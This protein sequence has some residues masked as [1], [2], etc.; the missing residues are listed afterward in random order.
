MM[1]SQRSLNPASFL[2][3]DAGD[4]ST[5][6]QK[7]RGWGERLWGNRGQGHF[8]GRARQLTSS[9]IGRANFRGLRWAAPQILPDYNQIGARL[10]RHGVPCRWDTETVIVPAS[11][12]RSESG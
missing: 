6:R 10:G 11:E 3:P 9:A 2:R 1:G 4:P 7:T 12:T 5:T 8:Q